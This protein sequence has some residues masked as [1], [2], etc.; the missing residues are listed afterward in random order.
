MNTTPDV[1]EPIPAM[2][3][4]RE[5][6]DYGHRLLATGGDPASIAAGFRAAYGMLAMHRIRTEIQADITRSRP[7]VAPRP[8]TPSPV[9]MPVMP[10]MRTP[11]L[12]PVTYTV[13]EARALRQRS[14]SDARLERTGRR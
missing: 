3:T 1:L 12:G 7:T 9:A 8:V 14:R 4:E 5:V 10:A 11:R 13:P 2:T 6:L